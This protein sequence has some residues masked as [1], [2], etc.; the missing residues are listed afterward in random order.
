MYSYTSYI[1]LFF[2]SFFFFNYVSRF[3]SYR[4]HLPQRGVLQF[5]QGYH[6]RLQHGEH[7]RVSPVF[8]CAVCFTCALPVFRWSVGCFCV[9]RFA[10]VGG[11]RKNGVILIPP[12]GEVQCSVW[13][14]L[15]KYFPYIYPVLRTP[16]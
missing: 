6:R 15:L 10:A 5:S 1:C 11:H 12:C 14:F 4:R 8:S 16:I 2:F 7:V 13:V 9:V 3:R